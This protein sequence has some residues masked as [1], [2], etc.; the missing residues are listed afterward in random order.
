[1]KGRGHGVV[2]GTVQNMCDVTE[3][4]AQNF[5]KVWLCA[6]EGIYLATS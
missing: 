2:G 5:I 3:E 6:A 4:T 1:M